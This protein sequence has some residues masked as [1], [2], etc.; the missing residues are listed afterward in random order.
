MDLNQI[1]KTQADAFYDAYAKHYSLSKSIFNKSPEIIEA[2]RTIMDK[3]TIHAKP[4]PYRFDYSWYQFK[5]IKPLLLKSGYT[6][7]GNYIERVRSGGNVTKSES[8]VLV[9]GTRDLKPQ[10]PSS[11]GREA[12]N[13]EADKRE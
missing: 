2:A 9:L 10:W 13:G 8:G 11:E 6:E 7:L 5:E 1:I 4:D 3:N 12:A